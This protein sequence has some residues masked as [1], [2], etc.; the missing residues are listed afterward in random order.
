MRALAVICGV[1]VFS[2]LAHAQ[3]VK[4]GGATGVVVSGQA[5]LTT[6]GAAVAVM[7]TSAT[8]RFIVTDICV[9]TTGSP[10]PVI[11]RGLTFGNFAAGVNGSSGCQSFRTGI[12]LPQGETIE[13]RLPGDATGT[14]FCSVSGIESRK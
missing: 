7:T 4:G 14:S 5:F 11:V 3:A 9:G 10:N 12:A 6:P 8:S 13:C 1:L 2:A